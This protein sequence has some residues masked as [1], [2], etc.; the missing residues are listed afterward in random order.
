MTPAAKIKNNANLSVD[1]LIITNNNS[2]PKIH[3]GN[4][5]LRDFKEGQSFNNAAT[6]MKMKDNNLLIGGELAANNVTIAVENYLTIN[7]HLNVNNCSRECP[8]GTILMFAGLSAPNS[9]WLLCDGSAVSRSTYSVLF[10][11]IG[12]TFGA[13]NGS[14]TFNLPN[15]HEKHPLGADT[16]NS[17]NIANSGGQ[18]EHNH[19]IPDHSQS[20]SHDHNGGI[21]PAHNHI[22]DHN[23]T[24]THNHEY[25]HNHFTSHTHNFTS[26]THT[27][28]VAANAQYVGTKGTTSTAVNTHVHNVTVESSTAS[29]SETI[30]GTSSLSGVYTSNASIMASNNSTVNMIAIS[31]GGI[32]SGGGWANIFGVPNSSNNT[33]AYVKLRFMIRVF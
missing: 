8:V 26:H 22:Y 1:N 16:A 5:V 28:S 4:I 6:K 13:G 21:V 29:S 24:L 14:T 17:V 25:V 12:T 20:F 7:G 31:S 27:G 3:A 10:S 11:L 32:S 33:M 15:F 19:S 9:G 18:L 30:V 23:H 2:T